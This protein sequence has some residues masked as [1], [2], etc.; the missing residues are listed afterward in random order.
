[1]TRDEF[2]TKLRTLIAEMPKEERDDV[3]TYYNEY[4]DDAGPENEQD[5]IR[6]LGSPEAVACEV[7][8]GVFR[9]KQE[10]AQ[11]DA[12]SSQAAADP[13]QAQ[14]DTRNRRGLGALWGVILAIC[15]A[16]VAL[17]LAIAGVAVVAAL[18]ISV[19]AVVGSLIL[20]AVVLGVS[21][22]ASVLLSFTMT[23]LGGA[24]V[25]FFL[26]GGIFC[27]ALGVLFSVFMWKLAAWCFNGIASVVSNFLNRRRVQQ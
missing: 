22:I 20:V 10:T 14:A 12:R 25:L 17:P 6:Q 8:G 16:P 9:S 4:F 7:M 2:L 13:A 1:M 19:V 15:A 26:G 21:G 27:A 18:A 5:V 24:T 3:M 11:P 23:G